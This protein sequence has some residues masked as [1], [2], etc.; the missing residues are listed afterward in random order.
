MP[1]V[2]MR[3][4][5]LSAEHVLFPSLNCP[6]PM[7]AE[8]EPHL[9]RC[10]NTGGFSERMPTVMPLSISTK[11]HH[12]RKTLWRVK[13]AAAWG[14]GELT[15]ECRS[16]ADFANRKSVLMFYSINYDQTVVFLLHLCRLRTGASPSS[17]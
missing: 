16:P 15:L 12:E 1:T 8:G 17:P 5:S 7:L 3:G 9:Q 10:W 4:F 11:M 2:A 14:P 13:G 6:M